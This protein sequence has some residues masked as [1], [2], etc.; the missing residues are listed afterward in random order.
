MHKKAAESVFAYIGISTFIFPKNSRVKKKLL[1][2][3]AN[4]SKK[5]ANA[6]NF[7][8]TLKLLKLDYFTCYRYKLENIV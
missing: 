8:Q 5:F 6:S 2:L 7:V 3:D 4:S 1:E